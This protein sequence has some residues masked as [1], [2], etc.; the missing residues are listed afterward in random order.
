MLRILHRTDRNGYSDIFV[1]VLENIDQARI[2]G[3]ICHLQEIL[4]ASF[5]PNV[6][7]VDLWVPDSRALSAFFPDMSNAA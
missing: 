5:D 6:M 3:T 4:K 7:K 1:L 2:S